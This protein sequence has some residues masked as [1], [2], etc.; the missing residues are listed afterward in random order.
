MSQ[1]AST[2]L[3]SVCLLWLA[4]DPLN[5]RLL[6]LPHGNASRRVR[7]VVAARVWELVLF[8]VILMASVLTAWWFLVAETVPRGVLP[9]DQRWL[10]CWEL[11]TGCPLRAA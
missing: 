1:L 6:R 9:L 5:L 10:K 8:V 4:P 3:G 7:V 2:F 11:A